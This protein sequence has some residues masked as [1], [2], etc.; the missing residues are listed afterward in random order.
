M[1]EI[2]D[3]FPDSIN[4]GLL[5]G[6]TLLFYKVVSSI[7]NFIKKKKEAQK[8]FEKEV[9]EKERKRSKFDSR[10]NKVEDEIINIRKDFDRKNIEN[11]EG[12]LI[13]SRK[14]DKILDILIKPLK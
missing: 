10:L 7:I 8:S 3:I 14:I 9:L 13:L 1:K 2:L 6:L 11:K 5:V 4:T 12:F